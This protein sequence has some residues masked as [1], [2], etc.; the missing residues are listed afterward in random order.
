MLANTLS[1]RRRFLAGTA[2][3]GL[4]LKL[5]NSPAQDTVG[6]VNFYNWPDYTA[7]TTLTD[8]TQASGIDV[9]YEVFTSEDELFARLHGGNPGFDVI[10]PGNNNV[11]RMMKADM[12]MPLEHARLPH[13][14]NIDPF[15]LDP[16]FDPGRRFSLP[17][18]WG[19]VGI[20]YRRSAVGQTP[21]TWRELF[22]NT[23]Q[24]RR[25]ALLRDPS[26]VMRLAIK[27]MGKPLND[28]SEANIAAAEHMLAGQ[29]DNI[30][31]FAPDNGQ[32]LLRAGEV[33][34]AMEWNTDIRQTME[35]DDDIGFVLPEDGGLLWEDAMCIPVGAPNADN[36][37][38]LIN[39]LLSARAGAAIANYTR[40]ATPNQAALALLDSD[41]TTHPAIIPSTTAR[42]NSQ[43]PTLPTTTQHL[44]QSWTR[45][46]TGSDHRK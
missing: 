6:Q 38:A 21:R 14:D 27:A 17:Y 29:R 9:R 34:L 15:F 32:D 25:I 40:H 12:L 44:T 5:S 26:I 28:L 10:M 24:A 2:A 4:S 33:D 13:I 43:Y 37:H 18:L 45:L 7:P 46:T 30:L 19:S 16:A 1:G 35:V 41:Y 3:L 39:F 36:A 8:F 11:E 31:T 20:G 42:N 22:Q 23:G